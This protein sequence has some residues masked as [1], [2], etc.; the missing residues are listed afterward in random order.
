[1]AGFNL[2]FLM[3]II[4]VGAYILLDYNKL[5]KWKYLVLA[6][7]LVLDFF[8]LPGYFMPDYKNGEMQCGLPAL[9]ITFLFWTFGGGIVIITHFV[10]VSLKLCFGAKTFHNNNMINQ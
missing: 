7:W 2:I 10:Y 1:M 9:M 5:N 6:I 8:I 4:Q 3:F